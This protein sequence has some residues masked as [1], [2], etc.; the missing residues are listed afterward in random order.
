MSDYSR[1]TDRARKTMQLA[2]Q[3]AQWL[4]H[5]YLDD[6]HIFIGLCKETGGN[7]A[8]VFA[9]L[10]LDPTALIR[11]MRD[12]MV[13]GSQGTIGRLPLTDAAKRVVECSIEEARNLGH[14]YVGTEHILLGLLES[15]EAV[16]IFRL[17]GVTPESVR[18][19][20]LSLL[21]E[22]SKQPTRLDP[23]PGLVHAIQSEPLV[24]AMWQ[25]AERAG[26]SV[27][28]ALVAVA[29]E[30]L[31]DNVRYRR[32]EVER[33]MGFIVPTCCVCGQ[34]GSECRAFQCAGCKTGVVY[35][36]AQAS[37]TVV[38]SAP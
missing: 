36:P 19:N 24:A 27:E 12:A 21:A 2:N 20:L 31:A 14:N 32:A 34:P 11:Q 33:Q 23:P 22:Y 1:W 30:L 16:R 13:H 26:A 7:A 8:N 37:P 28:V 4:L 3:E 15:P 6:R 18:K 5:T 25:E 35:P 10:R 17:F 29:L 38:E 9:R